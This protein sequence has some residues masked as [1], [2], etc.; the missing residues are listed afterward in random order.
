MSDIPDGSTVE[1]EGSGAKPYVLKNT[2][3]VYSCNCP[4]WRNQSTPIERRT[5]KH[6]RK[7][8]GDDA[9]GARVGGALPPKIV[10][11][12]ADG[13]EIADT[14]PPI[15]LAQ[16]WDNE[17]DLTGWWMSEKLD[18]VRAWWDGRAFVSR[19]GNIYR[20]PA[21]FT[22]GLPEIPLD[23]ELWIDRKA[24]QRTVS[25]VRRQD[26][27]E[28]WR[29][30]RFRAFDAPTFAG[31]FED[32]VARVE[33]LLTPIG[34][35]YLIAHEHLLCEG[36]DHLR[37]ELARIEEAGGEG[38]M[39]RKPGSAYEVGRSETLLKVK[40]FHDAEAEV[41]GHEPGKGRH[42]GRLGAVRVKLADGTTFAVGTGFSDT[43]RGRPPAIGS[44]ITF[45][46]Q[47]LTD[48]GVPRFP[49]FVGERLD[50]L[51]TH[52]IPE[53]PMVEKK[54]A[55][56][57]RTTTEVPPTDA[58]PEATSS[59]AAAPSV[60]AAM[61]AQSTAAPATG[62]ASTPRYYECTEDGASK[63][64]EV[65]MSGNTVTTRWGKIGTPGQTKPKEF[66]SESA[67][68]KEYDKLVAEKTGKGYVETKAP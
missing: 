16:S 20:A 43:Q 3:G 28:Q 64:W 38:L 27:T 50:A 51:P 41:I 55:N 30:V 24:F 58:I 10:R 32:R 62:A 42:R 13:E 45:R 37:R 68:K 33:S 7:L 12:N 34:S 59:P 17:A 36:T 25:I 49:S 8:R 39:M 23:G 9:E 54:T 53:I 47:E 21:W 22:E 4:A 67:A 56:K 61:P 65:S 48:G 15:L 18:G 11:T 35:P 57:A 44:T 40:S 63:F 52:S 46:Y 6:L 29:L 1:M 19:L 14:A 2:G 31:T 60:A 66:A 26:E 5:C